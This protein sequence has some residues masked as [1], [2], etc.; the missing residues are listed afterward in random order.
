M[1]DEGRGEV[2][3]PLLAEVITITNTIIGSFGD[4]LSLK[5]LLR[6]LVR[7]NLEYCS[8][9]WTNNTLKQIGSIE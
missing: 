8:L 1:A 3:K 2:N 6:A 7:S 4:L 9:I 5:M